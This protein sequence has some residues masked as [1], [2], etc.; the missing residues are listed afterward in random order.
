MQRM[1]FTSIRRR[2]SLTSLLF[3]L[4]DS[5]SATTAG[6]GI[7]DRQQFERLYSRAEERTRKCFF[8][9]ENQSFLISYKTYK[10]LIK[11]YIV[12]EMQKSNQFLKYQNI[13]LFINS[14]SFSEEKKQFK[15]HS[16]YRVKCIKDKSTCHL[17]YFDKKQEK[18]LIFQRSPSC[19]ICSHKIAS[20]QHPT[21]KINKISQNLS[22]K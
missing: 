8:E 19:P 15:Y 18:D 22:Y 10:V 6:P 7:Q 4:D 1:F 21:N 2:D 13:L 11:L 5:G 20:E 12:I 17:H 3:Q 16:Y 14:L 9:V